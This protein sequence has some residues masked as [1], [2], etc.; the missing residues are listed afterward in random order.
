MGGL[1]SWRRF[2]YNGMTESSLVGLGSGSWRVGF[3]VWSV[4]LLFS[5]WG[6]GL[7]EGLSYYVALTVS[8]AM[9]A[10]ALEIHW[11]TITSNNPK[12]EAGN[13][14]PLSPKPYSCKT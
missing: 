8:S 6:L 10:Q 7:R 9:G 14:K 12:H 2:D 13:P 11:D 5:L 4:G 3:G 1:L